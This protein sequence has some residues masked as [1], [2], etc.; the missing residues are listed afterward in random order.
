MF[1]EGSLFIGLFMAA[2]AVVSVRDVALDRKRLFD[3]RLTEDERQRLTRFA[4]FVL[5]PLSVMAHEGGHALAVKLFGGEVV[6][7]GFY[8]FYGYVSHIGFYTPLEIA[9]IAFAGPLVNIVTGLAVIAWAWYRS[10]KPER[11]AGNYLL[12]IFGALS[13]FNALVFYPVFDALGGIAGDWEDIYS[14]E[15]PI[16]SILIALNHIAILA[17]AVI[18]WR[19]PRFQAAYGEKTGRRV[20]VVHTPIAGV[21]AASPAGS[22]DDLAA[23]QREMGG[24]LTVAAATAADGW[25]HPVQLLTDAQVGGSQVVL[26]WQSGGFNRA[27]LIHATVDDTSNQ[28]V[29]LHAAIEAPSMN[30]P[31]FQRA[32]ARIDGQ[33]TAHELIPYISRFLEYV[34]TWDGASVVSPN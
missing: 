15:T 3:A 31:P 28:R 2:L 12:F 30:V 1:G 6:D 14:R 11:V 20:T 10:M 26:R 13:L 33:P 19:N 23:R 32:L 7:F 24:L 16:F 34:D 18:L 22:N 4:A 21:G 9:T 27:L 8:F 25:R 5:L 29:E 17:A